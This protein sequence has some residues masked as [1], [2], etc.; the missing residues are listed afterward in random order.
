LFSVSTLPPCYFFVHPCPTLHCPVNGLSSLQINDQLAVHFSRFSCLV[1]PVFTPSHPSCF[2]PPNVMF[3]VSCF[4]F[5]GFPLPFASNMLV[6]GRPRPSGRGA[7]RGRPRGS[8]RGFISTRG[9]GITVNLTNSDLGLGKSMSC[10]WFLESVRRHVESQRRQ[11]VAATGY[12][13]CPVKGWGSVYCVGSDGQR[14]SVSRRPMSG[15]S[16]VSRTNIRRRRKE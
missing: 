10:D 6:T 11:N 5:P 15:Q 12:V 8:R 1:F 3:F 14:C 7:K 13:H 4:V 2:V 9:R 16:T